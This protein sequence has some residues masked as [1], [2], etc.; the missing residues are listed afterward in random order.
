ME[1]AEEKVTDKGR[2]RGTL[3][4]NVD[5]TG[6]RSYTVRISV[7]GIERRSEAEALLA[8]H[9]KDEGQLSLIEPGEPNPA[10][11]PSLSPRT[12]THR[13]KGGRGESVP[14]ATV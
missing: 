5:D 2:V 10:D 14:P 1:E 13:R 3:T 7:G 11:S 8:K 6:I 12:H 4:Y 9:M